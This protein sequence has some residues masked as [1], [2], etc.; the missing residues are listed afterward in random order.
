MA[1]LGIFFESA[2][3]I[4]GKHHPQVIINGKNIR[5]IEGGC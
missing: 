3:E 4:C 1:K 5:L 2:K